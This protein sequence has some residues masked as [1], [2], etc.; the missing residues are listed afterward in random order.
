MKLKP[1]K[2]YIKIPRKITHILKPDSEMTYCD[3]RVFVD[4]KHI[5]A[6]KP[7]G[8]LCAVCR[9]ESEVEE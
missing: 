8:L 7:R 9:E 5:H 1:A 2:I 6:K 3:M 4:E